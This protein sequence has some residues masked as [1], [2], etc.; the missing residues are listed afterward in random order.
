[1]ATDPINPINPIDDTDDSGTPDVSTQTTQNTGL[2]R[3]MQPMQRHLPGPQPGPQ[4]AARARPSRP[5]TRPVTRALTRAAP[6]V[7]PGGDDGGDDDGKTVARHA[8]TSLPDLPTNLDPRVADVLSLVLSAVPVGGHPP[9][10]YGTGHGLAGLEIHTSA[11]TAG[12]T[13]GRHVGQRRGI[14]AWQVWCAATWYTESRARLLTPRLSGSVEWEWKV[15][16]R[17]SYFAGYYDGVRES[18]GESFTR[19]TP[20][21]PGGMR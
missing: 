15:A 5:V 1:M 9:T 19:Q 7:P 12:H 20:E 17:L 4:P 3:P 16:D 2:P 6:A 10:M 18:A 14:T 13:W 8:P 21:T 11:Y